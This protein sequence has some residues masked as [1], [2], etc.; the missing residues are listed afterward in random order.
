[1]LATETNNPEK[2]WLI[3]DGVRVYPMRSQ[4]RFR[5]APSV[6]EELD[7]Q[8]VSRL[9]YSRTSDG[10]LVRP[11]SL[12][13]G[14]RDAPFTRLFVPPRSRSR[15]FLISGRRL[16]GEERDFE[17]FDAEYSTINDTL[18]VKLNNIT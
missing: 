7:W 15:M 1:M 2:H 17:G 9:V 6:I 18:K 5:I 16:F 3:A 13:D 4:V 10:V 8:N 14:A 12:E 11:Y